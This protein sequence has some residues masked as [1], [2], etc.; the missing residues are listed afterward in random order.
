MLNLH[1]DKKSC[2]E[3]RGEM[4]RSLETTDRMATLQVGGIGNLDH[5][6]GTSAVSEIKVP[7]R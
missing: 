3:N 1:R 4:R 5:N 2:V 7:M 6:R